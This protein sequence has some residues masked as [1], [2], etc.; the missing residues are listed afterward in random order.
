MDAVFV[1][2]NFLH[3][4]STVICKKNDLFR[5]TL[6]NGPLWYLAASSIYAAKQRSSCAQGGDD[7]ISPS[8]SA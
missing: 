7:S 2:I 8:A 6:F 5:S 3:S 4:E 1:V